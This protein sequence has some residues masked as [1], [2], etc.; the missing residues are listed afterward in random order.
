M[1]HGTLIRM[2]YYVKKKY[3]LFN[4]F[5]FSRISRGFVIVLSFIILWFFG[6]GVIFADTLDVDIK[7]IKLITQ[8]GVISLKKLKGQV[9][10]ID[11]WASWC[12]PCRKSFPWMNKIQARHQDKGFRIIAVNVDSDRE[13]AKKFLTQHH[14][15]FT[16]AFDPD[17]EAA[18]IFN[19]QGMPNSF[20]IGRDGLIHSSHVGF[21]EKD[22]VTIEAGI[23]DLVNQ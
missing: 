16:I 10:Y 23:E 17:G 6:V 13:L 11:F 21:R 22:I 3:W 19:V 15:N 9:V 2:D 7:N 14:T 12:G 5:L 18:K 4:Q 1:L 20:L 8:E